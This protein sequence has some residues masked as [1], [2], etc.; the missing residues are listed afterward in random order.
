MTHWSIPAFTIFASYSYYRQL[1]TDSKKRS[2]F[3]CWSEIFI[4]F[5]GTL[6]NKY[7][8]LGID[9]E[10]CD[11]NNDDN[12]NNGEEEMENAGNSDPE[13]AGNRSNV[14]EDVDHI[15]NYFSII[16]YSMLQLFYWFQTVTVG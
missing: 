11:E 4:G 7:V 10:G 8:D 15:G 12:I 3:Q 9:N 2:D 6:K 14:F 1:S 16:I 13:N 5:K